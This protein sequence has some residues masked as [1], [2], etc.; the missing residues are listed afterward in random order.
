[1]NRRGEP[2]LLRLIERASN[3][4]FF[5]G[6]ALRHYKTIHHMDDKAL[7]KWLGCK[8]DGLERLALCRCPSDSTSTFQSDVERIATFSSCSAERL[9]RLLR[10]VAA[11]TSLAQ[12]SNE[13][14]TET[15]LMAA[16]DR[17]PELKS[18]KGSR[19]SKSRGR[20]P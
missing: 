20:E 11:I 15:M 10:E 17:R 8:P 18:R 13:F 7:A 5:L 1:M 14:S 9:L 3:D 4:A 16:R 12:A 2:K 6:H 19:S